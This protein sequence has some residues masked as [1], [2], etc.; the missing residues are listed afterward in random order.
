MCDQLRYDTVFPSAAAVVDTPNIHRLSDRG[1][2]CTQAYSACP[3]CIPARYTVRTGCE[4]PSLGCFFNTEPSSLDGDRRTVEQRCGNYLARELSDRGYRTFGIGKFHTHPDPYEDLG[5]ED[6]IHTEELWETVEARERDGYIQFLAREYPE[7]SFIEQPHGERTSMYYTPQMRAVPQQA[8]VE[9]FVTKHAVDRIQSSDGRPFFGFVS[10]I[11]PHPPCAPPQPYNRMFDPEKM[12]GCITGDLDTDHMD[13]YLPWMNHLMWA[14]D[15]SDLQARALRARYYAEV[16]YLDTCIGRILD[17]VEQRDDAHNTMIC[18][19]SDHGDLLG[20]HHAWQ[21]ES[22]FEA[23]NHI[24][25]LLRWPVVLQGDRQVYDGLVSLADLFS[26]ATSVSGELV[27]RDGADLLYGLQNRQEIR[28]YLFGYHGQPGT[29]GFKMMVRT[30]QWKYI[31]MSNGGREQLFPFSGS[32]EFSAISKADEV[33]ELSRAYPH[34]C[35]ELR[36][37]GE[38]QAKREGLE[39]ALD[40]HGRYR[41]F[42]FRQFPRG[43]ARQFDRSQGIEDFMI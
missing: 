28:E 42:T 37:V 19:F 38:L 5:Y 7:Y 14:D 29:R 8:T 16:A 15:I 4:S 9:E 6:H 27:L 33:Q 11:G 10:F 41:T 40:T 24:P 18:F 21:K 43:R 17:T 32:Q 30:D 36:A 2:V 25:F 1:V 12:P 3:V 31:F 35:R 22:F 34:I 26:L 20:D 39:D 13:D 23:A